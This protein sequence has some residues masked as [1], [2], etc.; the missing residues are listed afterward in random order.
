MVDRLL[1]YQHIQ[2][3]KRGTTKRETPRGR[4]SSDSFLSQLVTVKSAAMRIAVFALMIILI[5]VILVAVIV[6]SDMLDKRPAAALSVSPKVDEPYPSPDAQAEIPVEPSAL[7]GV[8][9]EEEEVLGTGAH[10]VDRAEDLVYTC[11]E[12]ETLSEIAYAYNVGLYKLAAYNNIS[13]VHSITAGTQIRIPSYE[14]EKDIKPVSASVASSRLSVTDRENESAAPQR[15]LRINVEQKYDGNGVVATL[16][17]D[18][19]NSDMYAMSNFEWDLDYG[20]KGYGKRITYTFTEPRTYKVFLRARDENNRQIVSDVVYIH[21]PYPGT[22]VDPSASFLTINSIEDRLILEGQITQVFGSK[23]VDEAFNF[24][25]TN[26]LGQFVYAAKESGFFMF[27]LETDTYTKKINLFVSPVESYHVESTT[28]NWYRTQFQTGTLGNCGPAT[29]SMAIAW[30]IGEYVPVINVRQQIGFR[31]D[32]GTNFQELCNIMT[33]HG[34]QSRQVPISGKEDIFEMLDNGHLVIVLFYT[35]GVSNVRGDPME[36]LFGKY[37]PD[38]VGH[39][40]VIKGY[41]TDKEHFIVQDP[42]PSDW[43]SNS[44]RHDDGI[45]M[46]G[47]NRYYRADEMVSSL[48]VRTVIEVLP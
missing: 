33:G 23:Y 47:R 29:V 10:K 8:S 17:V 19:R 25:G 24:L 32:G 48:R 3:R 43:G 26:E 45:S 35:G 36:D 6:P 16:S 44:A 14:H 4:S 28:L 9:A 21:V 2:K 15:K 11:K 39:Y 12:G 34:V 31:G 40:V 20:L 41:S 22:Y 7:S 46:I 1:Q 5:G 18:E 13:D 27:T 42:I 38:A 37:Y 30:A